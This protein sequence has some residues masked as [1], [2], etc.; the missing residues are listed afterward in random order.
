VVVFGEILQRD[1]PSVPVPPPEKGH[2]PS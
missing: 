2:T 1:V